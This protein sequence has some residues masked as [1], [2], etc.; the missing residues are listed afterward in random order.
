MRYMLMKT[1]RDGQWFYKNGEG[2]GW[3]TSRRE[4]TTYSGEDFALRD[5][6][7]AFTREERV[8]ITVITIKPYEKR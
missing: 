1:T 7:N 8:L 3:K 2:R 6:A 4:G 5:R